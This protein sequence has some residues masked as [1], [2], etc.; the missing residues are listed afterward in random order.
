ME[1]KNKS[2]SKTETNKNKTSLQ[3]KSSRII[4][5]PTI[6]IPFYNACHFPFAVEQGKSLYHQLSHNFRY[7]MHPSDILAEILLELQRIEPE[8]FSNLQ[9]HPLKKT[10]GDEWQW[11]LILDNKSFVP[12][13]R[14]YNPPV[15]LPRDI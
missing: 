7:S 5:L 14:C 1:N 11:E 12:T 10:D 8:Q 6:P 2:K 15:N 4:M 3:N 9:I 13:I